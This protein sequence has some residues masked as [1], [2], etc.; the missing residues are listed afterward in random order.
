MTFALT[1][2]FGLGVEVT[3]IWLGPDIENQKRHNW[4]LFHLP[5]VSLGIVL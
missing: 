4:L 5:F 1:T 3:D 2:F